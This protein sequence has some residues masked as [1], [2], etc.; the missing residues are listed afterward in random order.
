MNN[1]NNGILNLQ[2]TNKG[3]EMSFLMY[4]DM[5]ILYKGDDA[6][7]ENMENLRF[8]IGPKSFYQTN[9]SEAPP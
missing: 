2:L 9:T 6:I 5:D 1:L 4:K 7:Y 3:G 8:K